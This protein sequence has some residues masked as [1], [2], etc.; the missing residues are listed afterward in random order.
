MVFGSQGGGPATQPSG[1]DEESRAS[2]DPPATPGL[3]RRASR[4]KGQGS[5]EQPSAPSLGQQSPK[6]L[7]WGRG[8]KEVKEVLLDRLG[9]TRE[10]TKSKAHILLDHRTGISLV[11]V[12]QDCHR[13]L[14]S[15]HR[16]RQQNFST[17][18]SLSTTVYPPCSHMP[19]HM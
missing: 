16:I 14:P 9:S 6:V 10:T 18:H 13:P 4:T 19:T 12:T 11:K 2:G 7:A 3:Q 15:H 17:D 5:A 8:G 1:P